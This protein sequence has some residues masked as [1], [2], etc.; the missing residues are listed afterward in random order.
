MR[1][2]DAPSGDGGLGAAGGIVV[3][4]PATDID[5]C[6]AGVVELYPFGAATRRREDFVDED[7]HPQY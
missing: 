7:A 5:G 1:R 3:N 2:H 4:A 6:I